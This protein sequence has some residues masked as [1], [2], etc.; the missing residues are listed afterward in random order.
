MALVTENITYP[1]GVTLDTAAKII[2]WIDSYNDAIN[3]V[4]YNGNNRKVIFQDTTLPVSKFQG[5]DLDFTGDS[6]YFTDWLANAI[7]GVKISTGVIF[8]NISVPTTRTTQGVMGLRVIDS[9]K[10]QNG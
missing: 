10:Q 5:F 1:G 6:M 9:S 4:D 3:S 7:Y 8:R 2:Y